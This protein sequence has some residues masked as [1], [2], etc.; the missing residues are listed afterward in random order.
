MTTYKYTSTITK[1]K[2]KGYAMCSLLTVFY[3]WL[4]WPTS[5]S[6]AIRNVL[7]SSLHHSVEIEVV[8]RLLHSCQYLF[9]T[10]NPSKGLLA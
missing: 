1:P 9:K 3:F 7:I 6:V 8:M 4:N 10:A 5:V 2:L